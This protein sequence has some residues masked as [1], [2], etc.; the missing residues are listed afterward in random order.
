M[1]AFVGMVSV[2]Y[3]P[4]CG[5]VSVLSR[6]SSDIS[7]VN[8]IRT[9]SQATSFASRPSGGTC[10]VE[11]IHDRNHQHRQQWRGY[12]AATIGAAMR[13]MISDPVPWPSMIGSSPAMMTVTVIAFGRTRCTA[14]SRIE[15]RMTALHVGRVQI[16][17][18]CASLTQKV[19]YAQ[20]IVVIEC[21]EIKKAL[22]RCKALTLL[23][24]ETDS[25]RRPSD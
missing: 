19:N 14:P 1:H 11:S 20:S 4:H 16:A 24:P 12:Y 23:A 21:A 5:H 15:H 18:G 8:S 10:R 9:T 7:M 22:H 2:H 3:R 17:S 6:G 25:N 13:C